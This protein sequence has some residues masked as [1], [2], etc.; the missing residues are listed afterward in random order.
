MLDFLIS[1]SYKLSSLQRE[2]YRQNP[3]QIEVFRTLYEFLYYFSLNH[4]GNI[5]AL[6]EKKYVKLFTYHLNLPELKKDA[7]LLLT[8]V[9]KDNDAAN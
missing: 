6:T 5:K 9:I 8:E 2:K 4:E 1:K 7:L 3:K